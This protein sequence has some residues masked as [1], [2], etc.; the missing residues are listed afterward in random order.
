[1]KLGWTLR[2]VVILVLAAIPA[3]GQGRRPHVQCDAV[4]G[5]DLKQRLGEWDGD[6]R[7]FCGPYLCSSTATALTCVTQATA[8]STGHGASTVVLGGTAHLFMMPVTGGG[9]GYA[10]R[11]FPSEAEARRVGYAPQRISP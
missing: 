3:H 8:L 10:M 1:M 5:L 4:Y 2:L 6:G 11:R 7:F 9:A